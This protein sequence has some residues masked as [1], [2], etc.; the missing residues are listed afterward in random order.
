M[1]ICCEWSMSPRRYSLGKRTESIEQTRGQIISVTRELLA[2]DGF[3]PFSVDEVARRADVARATVYYQFGS[4]GGLL[5]AVVEDIQRRAGQARI[6][7]EIEAADPRQALRNAFAAG[8]RF[9]AAEHLLVQKLTGLGMV[10]ADIGRAL[11][12]V[13]GNRLPLLARLVKR[14]ETGGYLSP[15][16]PPDR[17]LDLLWMLSSFEAFDQLYTGRSVPVS[18][19]AAML[20]DIAVQQL[21]GTAEESSR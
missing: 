10:D 5:E 11:S 16:C 1:I 21:T 13:T 18:R 15:Y 14:L 3:Q 9:W 20:A 6:A 8:C 19:A 7:E 2:E 4:K 17:A 12:T